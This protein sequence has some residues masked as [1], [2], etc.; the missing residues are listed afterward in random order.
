MPKAASTPRSAASPVAYVIEVDE[1]SAGLALCDQEGVH[2]V[3]CHRC[4]RCLDGVCFRSL[5]ALERR[6]GAV[7]RAG[8]RNRG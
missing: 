6:V 5:A 3:A 7:L 4:V 2:F 8:E 1:Q